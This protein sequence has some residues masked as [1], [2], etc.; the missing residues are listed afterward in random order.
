MIDEE[1]RKE[2]TSIPHADR[3]QTSYDYEAERE[4]WRLRRD[5]LL[6][7]FSLGIV[8]VVIVAAIAT[9]LKDPYTVGAVLAGAFGL[10]GSPFFIRADERNK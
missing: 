6:T 4:R 10:L 9:D 2:Q 1:R 5:K 8:A 7:F 3:R